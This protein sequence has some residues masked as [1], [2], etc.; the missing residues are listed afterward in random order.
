MRI[1]DDKKTR[2]IKHLVT[3]AF[4]GDAGAGRTGFWPI[5]DGMKKNRTIIHGVLKISTLE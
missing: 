4:A 1:N 3:L 2:L 5:I